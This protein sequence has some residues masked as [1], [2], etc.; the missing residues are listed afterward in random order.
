MSAR[1]SDREPRDH[2]RPIVWREPGPRGW[3]RTTGGAMLWSLA[4][5]VLLWFGT[6]VL[7]A[8]LR[9]EFDVTIPRAVRSWAPIA[10]FALALVVLAFVLV[11][12]SQRL[13]L[14]DAARSAVAASADQTAP[15]DP[16][17]PDHPT[18]PDHLT[19]SND[20]TATTTTNAIRPAGPSYRSTAATVGSSLGIAALGALIGGGATLALGFGVLLVWAV[21]TPEIMWFAL[22]LPVLGLV[23]A[24]VGAA[25]AVGRRR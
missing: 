2:G 22:G 23:G 7:L 3:G 21:F 4:G 25:V 15:N 16:T 10:V 20:S 6:T 13:A 8:I 24:L 5:A 12:R 14:A 1:T 18:A 19:A 17:T 11:R 9:E